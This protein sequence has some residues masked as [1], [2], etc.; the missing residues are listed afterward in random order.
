MNSL[1][2]IIVAFLG[3]IIAYHTYGKFLARKIFNLTKSFKTPS[4]QFRDD[5]DYVPT[6]KEILFGHHF[7]S[8]AG[9]TPIVGPAIGVIWGW[10]PALLWI[11]FGSIFMGAVHDFGALVASLRN[12]GKSI[13]DIARDIISPRVRTIFLFI[14]FFELWIVIA[15][16]AMIIA[17]LFDMYPES[18]FPVWMEIPIAV[19][20]GMMIYKR[21]KSLTF[22]GIIA[23]VLMYITIIIGAYLPKYIP[24]KMPSLF[25]FQPVIIWMIVLFI[26]CYIASTLP[27]WKLLQPRD[28]INGHELLIMM[29][30]LFVG[31]V[32]AHPAIVAPAINISPKNAPP[33]LPF[34]FIFI[35]CGA[36]SGFHSLVSSGTSSKQ[37]SS[38]SHAQFVGYGGMLTEGAL[39]ILALVAVSAGI[40]LGLKTDAGLLT[41]TSAWTYHYSSW[42][43]A[44][45]LADKIHAFVTGA[46]NIL[47][48]LGI[49][50]NISASIIGVFLVSF[51]AT[52]L[53]SATRIQRYAVSE[54]T[55]D[56][57][58]HFLSYRHTSTLFV[59][60]TAM[61]LAFAQKDGRGAL[62]LF[63]LF[64]TVNQLLAGLSLLVVSVYLYKR[65]KPIAYSLLPML[66]MIIMTG[67]AMIVNVKDFFQ[68]G[69]YHLFIIGVLVFLL[70][71][72]MIM[73]SIIIMRKQGKIL[74]TT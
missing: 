62:I 35:A 58:L 66:F 45:G 40:G 22:V 31:A 5:V 65:R 15:I 24:M 11:F 68:G 44:Q 10:V 49:P 32:I 60:I 47:G 63:P 41:G 74:K 54:L 51:G 72:W 37:I 3:F 33:M 7:T 16:F 27:V 8:I 19:W 57:H 48:S 12:K 17:M 55:S 25:G 30:L 64:G 14:I 6:K 28:Y 59:V 67:W 70:E 34:V 26:Y 36:V 23:V 2:I 21:K 38:E 46:V 71:I 69:Q 1:V 20:L 42:Q 39:A 29:F 13:G 53:D 18:I 61:L 43:A 52:T 9:L 73:E 56:T 4:H 50:K